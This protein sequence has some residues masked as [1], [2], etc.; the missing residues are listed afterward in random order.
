MHVSDIDLGDDIEI[1]F[2]ADFTVVTIVPPE[3]GS[4]EGEGEEDGEEV[5]VAEEAEV[6]AAE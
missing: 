4:D 2:D 6:A 3:T 1:P 5:A